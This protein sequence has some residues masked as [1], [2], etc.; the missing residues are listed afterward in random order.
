MVNCN[1]EVDGLC[2]A[3]EST[4]LRIQ[5]ILLELQTTAEEENRGYNRKEVD[6]AINLCDEIVRATTK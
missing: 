1:S 4:L 6:A 5:S 3:Y 2:K